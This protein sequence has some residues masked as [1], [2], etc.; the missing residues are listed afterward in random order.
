MPMGRAVKIVV[1]CNPDDYWTVGM[2]NADGVRLS[3][4]VG[5][6]GEAGKKGAIDFAHRLA[7]H[8]G[9]GAVEVIEKGDK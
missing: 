8:A 2:E 3:N 9:V 7:A 1:Q 4:T 5:S 6:A